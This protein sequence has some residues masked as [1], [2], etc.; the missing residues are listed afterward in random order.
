MIKELQNYSTLNCHLPAINWTKL[1]A[2][3]VAS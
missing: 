1:N 3:V 2:K